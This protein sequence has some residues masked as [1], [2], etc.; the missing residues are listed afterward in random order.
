M[1]HKFLFS[2]L[3]VLSV[4][5]CGSQQTTAS[6]SGTEFGSK[7]DSVF[8]SLQR[9]PC[10]GKCPAYTVTILADG[11][12]H[13]T[14]RSNAPREGEFTGRVDKALMQALYDRA[15]S[16]GF[17][18]FQD[19]YDGQVTD[20]P[21]TI[22]RVNASG[23]DKKVVGRVKTPPAFKPFA[24]YADSLLASVEWTLVAPDK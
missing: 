21:S 19:K 5:S 20:L 24:S 17:F 8:F 10:F 9:T 7:S 12:A 16:I 18:G 1:L 4:A 3:I 14:G 11:S 23:K 6:A 2:A 13:Y 15:S 22:I